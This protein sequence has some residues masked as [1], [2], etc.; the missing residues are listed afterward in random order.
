MKL[1]LRDSSGGSTSVADAT[2]PEANL[3]ILDMAPRVDRG[4]DGLGLT[5]RTL[6]RAMPKKF[7]RSGLVKRPLPS[8]MLAATDTAARLS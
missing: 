1:S 2:E 4:K 5:G 7:L 3:P 6:S 8:A